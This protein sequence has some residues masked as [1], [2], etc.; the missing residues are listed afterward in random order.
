MDVAQRIGKVAVDDQDR[1]ISP[2][3]IEKATLRTE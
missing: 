2:V 1:P 3:V